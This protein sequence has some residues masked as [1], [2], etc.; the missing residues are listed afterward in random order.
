MYFT[1]IDIIHV[2]ASKGNKALHLSAFFY[3]IWEPNS[4]GLF[5]QGPHE[6]L[7]PTQ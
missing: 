5:L 2:N 1:C 7:P 6:V 3:N 4:P